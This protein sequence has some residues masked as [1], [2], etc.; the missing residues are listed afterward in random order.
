MPDCKERGNIPPAVPGAPVSDS[1]AKQ[2]PAT[3]TL[4][5]VRR[6]PGRLRPT[7][8]LAVASFV[9]SLR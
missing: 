3:Y 2:H 5:L 4:D 1:W 9:E 6:D 8:D 7:D